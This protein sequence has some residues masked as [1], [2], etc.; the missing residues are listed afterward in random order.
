MYR[1]RESGGAT[2]RVRERDGV[3][4]EKK[5]EMEQGRWRE[6]KGRQAA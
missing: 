3:K 1:E 5:M 6:M 2:R 4:S